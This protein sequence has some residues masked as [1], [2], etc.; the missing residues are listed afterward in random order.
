MGRS[1]CLPAVTR[2]IL[3]YTKTQAWLLQNRLCPP[4]APHTGQLMVWYW[5]H[6]EKSCWQCLC[7]NLSS[8]YSVT[9]KNPKPWRAVLGARQEVAEDGHRSGCVEVMCCGNSEKLL[10]FPMNVWKLQLNSI[11]SSIKHIYFVAK[12][13]KSLLWTNA[14]YSLESQQDTKSNPHLYCFFPPLTPP[15]S[16]LSCC[17]CCPGSNQSSPIKEECYL[18]F[19]IEHWFESLSLSLARCRFKRMPPGS[20]R[21]HSSHTTSFFASKWLSHWYWSAVLLAL[22]QIYYGHCAAGIELPFKRG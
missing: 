22:L 15:S 9:L 19:G 17:I 18:Q 13:L 10:F 2:M 4:V 20:D 12:P 21:K 1:L 3:I 16:L 11:S 7:I 8:T 14:H 6:T 5:W